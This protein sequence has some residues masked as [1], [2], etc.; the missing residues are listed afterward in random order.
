MISTNIGMKGEN[1]MEQVESAK[2][3]EEW[4]PQEGDIFRKKGTENPLYQ[5]CGKVCYSH[6]AFVQ[7]MESGIAGG[8]IY[9]STLVSE[10]ELVERPKKLEEALEDLF[11]SLRISFMQNGTG[12]GDERRERHG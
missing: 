2:K 11:E 12:E 10:Y 1:S 5:L 9:V 8:E 4:I 6:F 3:R 7:I